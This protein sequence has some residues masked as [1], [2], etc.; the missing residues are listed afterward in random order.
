MSD[1]P[2][3]VT[4]LQRVKGRKDQPATVASETKIVATEE[5]ARATAAEAKYPDPAT[6]E[7]IARLIAENEIE[8]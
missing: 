2:Y 1:I 4:E 8:E 3:T 6:P 7:E 5:L